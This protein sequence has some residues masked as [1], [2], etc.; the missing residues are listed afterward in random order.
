MND[1]LRTNAIV[2]VCQNN[3]IRIENFIGS[4]HT[5]PIFNV[6]Y[7]LDFTIRQQIEVYLGEDTL[8]ICANTTSHSRKINIVTG[9]RERIFGSQLQVVYAPEVN[10]SRSLHYTVEKSILFGC[11]HCVILL[12]YRRAFGTYSLISMYMVATILDNSFD[13]TSYKIKYIIK[14]FQYSNFFFLYRHNAY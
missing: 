13:G 5:L 7:I 14:Q 2:C 4:P 12:E 3:L 11:F 9:F 8:S 6:L 1:S 10:G